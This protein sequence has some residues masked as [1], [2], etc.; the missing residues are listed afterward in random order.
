MAATKKV[1]AVLEILETTPL[2]IEAIEAFQQL[3]PVSNFSYENANEVFDEY[4]HV[5]EKKIA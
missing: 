2:D 5:V 1:D 4:L 3:V